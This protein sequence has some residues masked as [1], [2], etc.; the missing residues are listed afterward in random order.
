MSQTV[1]EVAAADAYDQ[2]PGSVAAQLLQDVKRLLDSGLSAETLAIVWLAAVDSGYDIDRFGTDGRDWSQQMVEVCEE[3]L[4]DVAPTYRP[5]VPEAR[6]DLIEMVMHEVLAVEPLA[7][8]KAVSPTCHLIAGTAVM[9]ALKQVVTRVDP[10]LGFRLFLRAM[11]A[12]RMPLTE[13]QY[14]RYETLRRT[15][16]YSEDYL[17]QIEQLVRR[18]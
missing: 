15:F 8:H 16:D 11:W 3:R 14:T 9:A 6:T 12:L 17:M 13:D 5:S 7:A 18:D 1:R 2:T 4:R 10:D